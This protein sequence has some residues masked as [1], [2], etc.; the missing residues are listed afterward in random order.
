MWLLPYLF[1][2]ECSD[3]AGLVLQAGFPSLLNVSHVPQIPHQHPATC[4][5]HNESVPRHRE[6]VDLPKKK[7]Y[8]QYLTLILAWKTPALCTEQAASSEHWHNWSYL[9]WNAQQHNS[10]Q[11]S[12]RTQ[13]W[14]KQQEHAAGQWE[15]PDV[16]FKSSKTIPSI[17]FTYLNS[18]RKT[19]TKKQEGKWWILEL[20]SAWFCIPTVSLWCCSL[21]LQN[22]FTYFL[23]CFPP[24]GNQVFFFIK[25]IFWVELHVNK[26]K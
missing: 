22:H 2:G 17:K 8:L 6:G 23:L 10:L 20:I 7:K 4:C 25:Q 19:H 9:P 24:P 13:I 16:E 26:R 15:H 5:P 14:E 11:L 18:K 21:V 12:L 3:A 1:V